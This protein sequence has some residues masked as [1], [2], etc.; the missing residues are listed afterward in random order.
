MLAPAA[1]A[2]AADLTGRRSQDRPPL[3]FRPRQKGEGASELE[4]ENKQIES[5]SSSLKELH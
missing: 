2:C 5:L 4:K 1:V 3:S